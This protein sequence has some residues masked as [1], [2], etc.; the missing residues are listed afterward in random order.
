MRDA[1]IEGN[2]TREMLENVSDGQSRRTI[3]ERSQMGYISKCRVMTRILNRI[4]DLREDA[5]ELDADGVALE[6]T[7]A[8]R[9][10]FRLRLPITVDTARCLFAAIS[11]DGS[12]TMLIF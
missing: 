11:I 2:L 3:V 8:A 10:V 7:G 12:L 1:P 4:V 9:G 6:H 5:L